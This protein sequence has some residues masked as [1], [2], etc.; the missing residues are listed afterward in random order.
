MAES[1]ERAGPGAALEGGYAA[2]IAVDRFVQVEEHAVEPGAAAEGGA[3]AGA[4]TAERMRTLPGAQPFRLLNEKLTWTILCV[5]VTR[6]DDRTVSC[7][8]YY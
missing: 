1:R 2:G 7:C 5:C 6:P 3:R 4:N 8:V